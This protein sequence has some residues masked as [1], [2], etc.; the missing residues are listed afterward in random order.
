MFKRYYKRTNYIKSLHKIKTP[1][2]KL[3]KNVYVR[4]YSSI[5]YFVQKDDLFKL[6]FL[7]EYKQLVKNKYNSNQNIFLKKSFK[8]C[9]LKTKLNPFKIKNSLYPFL[10]SKKINATKKKF[11][12]VKKKNL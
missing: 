3:K 11:D 9:Y 1:R 6:A 7:F 8:A 2:N 10:L 5:K 12:W 4:F